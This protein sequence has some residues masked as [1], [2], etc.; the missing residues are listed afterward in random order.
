MSNSDSDESDREGPAIRE[1][2]L[3]FRGGSKPPK[4]PYQLRRYHIVHD[5]VREACAAGRGT[6][7]GDA[8]APLRVPHARGHDR[9]TAR[10]PTCLVSRSATGAPVVR[11]WRDIGLPGRAGAFVDVQTLPV[12]AHCDVGTPPAVCPAVGAAASMTRPQRCA[13]QACPTPPSPES[14][15]ARLSSSRAGNLSR[16]P[17]GSLHRLHSDQCHN[18]NRPGRCP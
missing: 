10:G 9:T 5:P 14:R 4:S 1:I 7:R 12:H 6:A 3:E 11:F 18:R 15:P 2:S 16:R 13:W 17:T 8:L